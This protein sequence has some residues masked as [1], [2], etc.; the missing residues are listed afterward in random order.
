M[1]SPL[2]LINPT[3]GGPRPASFVA[4]GARVLGIGGG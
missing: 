1:P 2:L 4:T 3:A